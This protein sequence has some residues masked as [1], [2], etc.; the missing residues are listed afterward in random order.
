MR[1]LAC[2]VCLLLPIP[3]LA[4][5][6]PAPPLPAVTVV[7]CPT[8]DDAVE[9]VRAHRE[10]ISAR[11]AA[12]HLDAA[13]VRPLLDPAVCAA[14]L[15][16]T[17]DERSPDVVVWLRG[18]TRNGATLVRTTVTF[19]L[20]APEVRLK[21]RGRTFTASLSAA[22]VELPW[23]A[24]VAKPAK[25]TGARAIP[26]GTAEPSQPEFPLIEGLLE[27]FA[28]RKLLAT[29]PP[30]APRSASL[31]L[32]RKAALR[33][34]RAADDPALEDLASDASAVIKQLRALLLLDGGC[35]EETPAGLLH[36]SA[37]LAPYSAEARG[38]AALAQLREAYEPNPCA[39]SAEEQLIDTVA[40]DPWNQAAVA[41]LAVFYELAS[42]AP[43]GGDRPGQQVPIDVAA[44]RLETIWKGEAPLPP[45]C[46]E[47]GG[48]PI[49]TKSTR[50]DLLRSLALGMHLELTLARDGTGWGLRLGATVPWPREMAL[51]PGTA[52]WTRVSFG[53]GPRYRARIGRVS[54][55]GSAAL[56]VAPVVATGHGFAITR[57]STGVD[58]GADL[59]ARLRVQLGSISAW[60]G[61]G[62]SYFF[63]QK[64]RSW[65]NLELQV[66]RLQERRLLPQ[67]DVSVLSGI[68]T[69]IWL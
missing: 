9:A 45:R 32:N 58:L 37:R 54:L 68:S 31:E 17:I 3:V 12:T 51:G 59:G 47:F 26:D 67:V 1:R 42:N 25:G 57:S 53:L 39:A 21:V 5:V 29:Q 62:G 27:L 2:L 14:V 35:H 8:S 60:V 13:T 16:G 44:Q 15:G 40:L 7:V 66:D 63:S 4:A 50:E 69:F 65:P 33:A 61:L 24:V 48:G 10:A 49:L 43:A 41:N 55:E 6:D 52:S 20:D 38:L 36:A 11:A 64:I 30:G 46:L 22:A 56:L 23:I 28:Y 34:L 19:H 18:R